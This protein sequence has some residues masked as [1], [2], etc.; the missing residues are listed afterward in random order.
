LKLK[1]TQKRQE[2]SLENAFRD[3]LANP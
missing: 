3:K 1:D 2:K